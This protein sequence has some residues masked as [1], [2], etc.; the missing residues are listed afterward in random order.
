M[1]HIHGGDIYSRKITHDFSANINY[2]G[3]PDSVKKA[4]VL[5]IDDAVHYPDPACRR[6]ISLLAQKEKTDAGSLICG[7][8]AADLLYSLC[9]AFGCRSAAVLCPSFFEYEQAVT[10]CGGKVKRIFL[11]EEKGFAPDEET[12]E[13]IRAFRPQLLFLGNPNN[14]TGRTLPADWIRR[15][16]QIRSEEDLL[17]VIDESF[18][19]FMTGSDRNRTL[20]AVRLTGEYP[21]LFVLK[22]FTKLYAIPGIRFGYGICQNKD[23]LEKMRGR[24]QPWGVSSVA[25]AAACACCGETEF[26][27]RTA[28]AVAENRELLKKGLSGLGF[29]VT[30]GAA[31]NFLLF[32]GEEGLEERLL[33][34][35]IL[36]R[37][38]SN[39]PG[40]SDKWYRVCV[41]SREENETLLQALRS[42]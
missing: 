41:R 30:E 40:L 14:P 32:S 1:G 29:H 23:L 10:A 6:V 36:I 27:E 28:A 8:G 4:A 11:K 39:F 9:L 12:L 31:A 13:E 2:L 35:G 38:C 37:G 20:E 7:N 21:N 17:T 25:Q 33:E 18:A 22:S 42:R 34:K 3:M 19:G 24:M 26:A 15:V 5:T 16:L